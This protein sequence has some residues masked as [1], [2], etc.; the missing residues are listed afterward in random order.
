MLAGRCVGVGL[1]YARECARSSVVLLQGQQCGQWLSRAAGQSR[2]ERCH[3][4]DRRT[5]IAPPKLPPGTN[6][7]ALCYR[8]DAAMCAPDVAS[9]QRFEWTPLESAAEREAWV[10]LAPRPHFSWR[11]LTGREAQRCN[12]MAA[13]ARAA[14]PSSRRTTDPI[15]D[16]QP[17]QCE[18]RENG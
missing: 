18:K 12:E 6:G 3:P 15:I 8:V 1:A 11:W 4:V 17:D 5:V 13:C 16:P 9:L 2:A 14:V 10:V 7:S